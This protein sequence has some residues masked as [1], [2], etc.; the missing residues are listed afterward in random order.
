MKFLDRDVAPLGM[1]CWAIG[2][3]MYSGERSVGWAG[4]DDAAAVRAIH[5]ALD[6][7][8]R[9]FDTAAAYGAGHSER[10]LGKALAARPE[11][12]IVSKLG[13]AIDEGERRII[14]EQRAA[15]AVL[16]AIDASRRRLGRERIDLM[17][18]HLNSLP[19][20]EAEPIFDQLERARAEGRIGAF[21]W[22]TD[23]P[24]SVDAMAARAGFVAVEHAMNVFVDVPGVQDCVRR[25]GLTA[26][27]RSP[28][29]MGVLTGKFDA[30]SRLPDDDVRA[31][32]ADWNGYFRD[33]RVAPGCLD[34]LD[35]IREL[36]RTGGRTL[37]QGALGWLLA[38]SPVNLP[39][40][41][42]RNEAQVRDNAGA[43]EHGPLPADVMAAIENLL[44][45][46]PEGPPRDR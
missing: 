10:L 16:P 27:I 39:L 41:G 4:A 7:G 38:K 23:Y 37:A 30:G 36:L 34:Q 6:A 3:A 28:L 13:V 8:I 5:A 33:G 21:G 1:G 25:H 31:S 46:E 20:A 44:T 11:A 45:R 2:G 15:D 19:V 32:N 35:A 22:S 26:L 40:P 14:G 17:L 29:A 42:A 24:A 43:I 9:V 12:L 18:L